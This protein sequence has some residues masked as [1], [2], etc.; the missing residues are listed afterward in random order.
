MAKECPVVL[1]SHETCAPE[2]RWSNVAAF[3]EEMLAG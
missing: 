2:R 1:F 3:L